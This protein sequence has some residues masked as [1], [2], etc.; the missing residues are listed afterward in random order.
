MYATH[1]HPIRS[2]MALLAAALAALVLAVS[3]R[4]VSDDLGS[5]G[6]SSSPAAPATVTKLEP[7]RHG[8]PYWVKDP[9]ASPLLPLE[10]PVK[11]TTK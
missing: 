6:T 1:L 4:L 2:L 11:R 9:L 8:K 10:A 3:V 5:G 7:A